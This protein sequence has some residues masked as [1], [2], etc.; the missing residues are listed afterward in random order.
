[1]PSIPRTHDPRPTWAILS[2][3]SRLLWAIPTNPRRTL[4]WTGSEGERHERDRSDLSRCFCYCYCFC[5]CSCFCQSRF[6]TSL[7]GIGP[8]PT[9][10]H[11]AHTQHKHNTA[12]H[13][14][15]PSPLSKAEAIEG[16]LPLLFH[17][18]DCRFHPP[19]SPVAPITLW[20]PYPGRWVLRD[21]KG[22][23]VG[24]LT[25][26]GLSRTLTREVRSTDRVPPS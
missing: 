23:W 22:P 18:L 9:H 25:H 6:H 16:P 7:C 8:P 3:L 14:T 24:T 2:G 19:N 4:A 1:M 11:N 17:L 13:R 12:P 21:R 15:H 5:S 26:P 20:L 10:A